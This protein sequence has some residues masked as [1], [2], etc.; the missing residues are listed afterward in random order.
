MRA[1]PATLG[2]GNATPSELLL[3][4]EA[5]P[6]VFSKGREFLPAV[7]EVFEVVLLPFGEG[8]D[9]ALDGACCLR[10]GQLGVLPIV[11]CVRE[12]DEINTKSR[13]GG[14]RL[15]LGVYGG[16]DC[17]KT[18]FPPCRLR[19]PH[20]HAVHDAIHHDGKKKRPMAVQK[21]RL[22]P[23]QKQLLVEAPPQILLKPLPCPPQGA[24]VYWSPSPNPPQGAG[25]P[26]EA[27]PHPSPR[28]GS[29]FPLCLRVLGWCSF[30]LGK[31][32]MGPAVGRYAPLATPTELLLLGECPSPNPPQGAG[33]PFCCV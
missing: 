15:R 18:S 1:S 21:V 31:A 23:V 14:W 16:A 2:W 28:G 19:H 20:R 27:P 22:S 4:V 33:V 24:G 12:D 11:Y 30:P 32:G 7:F 8:W 29:P 26:L 6:Q 10:R 17:R 25:V 5:P 13:G 9:G 3:L